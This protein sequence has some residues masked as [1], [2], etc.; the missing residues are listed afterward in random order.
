MTKLYC[1]I[2][3]G[4]SGGITII[5]SNENIIKKYI[6]PLNEDNM[7]DIPEIVKILTEFK[8]DVYSIERTWANRING[9]KSNFLSGFHVGV[10]HGIVSALGYDWVSPVA[11]TWQK[12]ILTGTQAR[13][14]KEASINFCL[15]KWPDEDWKRTKRCKKCH[16]GL[17]DSSCI[18]LW[19]KRKDI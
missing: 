5:D 4:K 18:A 9:S 7:Y 17:T 12:E 8:I 6:M 1:G 16:D 11:R 2:D 19:A 10:A 15:K 13:D 14:T 3:N